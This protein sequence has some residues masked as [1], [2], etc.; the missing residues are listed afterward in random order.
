MIIAL[1]EVAELL[2]AAAAYF[3]NEYLNLPL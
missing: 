2:G 1:F 3:K